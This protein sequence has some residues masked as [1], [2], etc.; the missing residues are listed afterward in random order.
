MAFYHEVY[1]DVIK[2]LR[3]IDQF[4]KIL[5]HFKLS[6]DDIGKLEIIDQLKQNGHFS[7]L[8]IQMTTHKDNKES[9]RYRMLGNNHFAAKTNADYL[10]ALKFYNQSICYAENNSE[11]LSLG[12]ANRSAVY[13]TLELYDD[14]LENIKSA[15]ELPYPARLM[16]KLNDRERKSLEL[17]K[18]DHVVPLPRPQLS[19]PASD[20][21]PL[22][23][24]A[25]CLKLEKDSQYGRHVITTADLKAGD[26]VA[27]NESFCSTL[28]IEYKYERCQ[29][30]L[31]EH[32][33]NLI[34]CKDCASVM[35][36]GKTCYDEAYEKFH[37]FECPIIGYMEKMFCEDLTATFRTVICAVTTFDSVDDLVTFVQESKGLDLTILSCNYNN[38]SKDSYGPVYCLSEGQYNAFDEFTCCITASLIYQPLL[39]HTEFKNTFTTTKAITTL[40]ELALHTM[41]TMAIN[42]TRS[43]L[44]DGNLLK[45]F[46]IGCHPL[47]SMLSHSCSPNMVTSSYKNTMVFTVSKPIKAGEQLFDNYE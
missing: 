16:D 11:E 24:I 7:P 4:D 41:K 15:K 47:R 33:Y 32:N 45:N 43:I 44:L 18:T 42:R 31:D 3:S 10:I 29:N 8:K 28:P 6:K 14:C 13:L 38:K 22:A 30:C 1:K 34:P 25:D 17:R 35:F 39:E 19:F 21:V 9:A 5:T 2:K 46:A 12:M 23:S 36:C 26:V 37:K 40:K 27:I 20:K